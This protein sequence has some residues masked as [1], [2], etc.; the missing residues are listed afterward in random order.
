M[1]TFSNVP[2]VTAAVS[3]SAV[4]NGTMYT[5]PANSYAVINAILNHAAGVSAS[6][7]YLRVA[8]K[9]VAAVGWDGAKSYSSSFGSKQQEMNGMYNGTFGPIYV[10]PGQAVTADLSSGGS[11]DITGVQ[12]TNGG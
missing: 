7:V 11:I 1:S 12:F 3:A 8:G 2:S 5:C 6:T 10:G 9:I 4:A